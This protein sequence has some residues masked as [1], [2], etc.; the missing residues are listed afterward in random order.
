MHIGNFT[1]PTN[2]FILDMEVDDYVLL[3]KS[4]ID[5]FKALIDV[6]NGQL[7]FVLDM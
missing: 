6:S 4:F 1:I 2:F 7:K 5:P 3:G